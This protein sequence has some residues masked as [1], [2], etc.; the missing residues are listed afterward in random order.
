MSIKQSIKER[1]EQLDLL[2]AFAQ[3]ES[4]LS[5]NS[6]L[7]YG[8]ES[9]GKSYTVKSYLD[10]HKIKHSWIQCD[11]CISFKILLQRILKA[12]QVDSGK[13]PSEEVLID[14]NTISSFDSFISELQDFFTTKQYTDQHYIVLDRADL[15]IEE[16][17]DIF[18]KFVKLHE[19]TRVPN[20]T[21]IFITSTQPRKLITTALPTIFFGNYNSTQIT[22]ILEKKPL[23]GFSP[24]LNIPPASINRFWQNYIGIIVES[25]FPYTTNINVLRRIATKLWGKF[26]EE[27]ERGKLQTSEFLALYRLN[28]GL[29]SSNYAFETSLKNEEDEASELQTI[30]SGFPIISKYIIIAGYLASFNESKYDWVFFSKLKDFHKKKQHFRQSKYAATKLNSRLLEPSPFDLERLMAILNAIYSLENAKKLPSNLDI[31]TQISNLSSL[32]I[33]LK[34]SNVDYISAK[35]RWKINVNFSYVKAIADDI[36]FPLENYLAE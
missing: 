8:N 2:S 12:I 27:I 14:P 10:F 24:G 13:V 1:D 31:T 18:A 25:Y 5:V 32:K 11:E 30:S 20:L 17:E 15:I 6:I 33:L 22:R 21:I 29:L 35:T 28:V 3:K 36:N 4:S 26:T 16:G 23:C 19:A 34:S 9:S 7:V